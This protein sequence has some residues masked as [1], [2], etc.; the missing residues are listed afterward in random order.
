MVDVSGQDARAKLLIDTKGL[1]NQPE[2]I[3][4]KNKF[5]APSAFD[6]REVRNICGTYGQESACPVREMCLKW[7]LDHKEIWGVWGGLDESE[8][9]RTL[10]V[11]SIGHQKPRSRFP[12][13]PNCKSRPS[14]LRVT[15]ELDST[16]PTVY[17][18]S[19]KFS[20]RSRTSAQA[21]RSYQRTR[22]RKKPEVR[23]PRRR[24]VD[25]P[26]GKPVS[27]L[28]VA[29]QDPDGGLGLVASGG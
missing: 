6:R 1:C 4:K 20:W 26:V 29:A 18:V 11:D 23:V 15:Q 2:N 14:K 25:Q 22:G 9:R 12:N 21:V 7:A 17:C 10:W 8:L 28:P 5:F 16:V 19:C 27:A 13:C 3:D 24:V